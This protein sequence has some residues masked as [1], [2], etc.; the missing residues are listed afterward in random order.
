MVMWSGKKYSGPPLS[1]VVEKVG[2]G[3]HDSALVFVNVDVDP[4]GS[5]C[6]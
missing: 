4:D 5:R 1:E 2:K 6:V 3:K